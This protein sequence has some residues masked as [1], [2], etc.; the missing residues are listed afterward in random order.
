MFIVGC[1]Y[2]GT[3][4]ALRA[5]DAATPVSGVVRSAA[6]AEKLGEQMIP[7]LRCDLD[8][9]PLPAGSTEGQEVYY[10]APPPSAGVQDTRMRRFIAGLADSGQPRRIVYLSTTG[11][12]GDCHGE[13]VDERRP[14]NPQVDRAHRRWDAEQVLQA[15][16][17]RSGGELVILRVAG[18]YGPGKLPLARLR[19]G[20]PMVDE[21]DAPWTNRIHADDLVSACLAAMHKGVDGEV[22]NACDGN[23]GNMSDY[24][25]QVAEMAGIAPP[26]LISLA[27]ARE[28]LSP[29]MLSYLGESRRLSNAKLL[30]DTGLQLRYPGL[31]E[32]LCACFEASVDS[33][34]S[35]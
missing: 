4:L 34:E 31:P 33:H 7:V 35:A 22:Y 9:E 29:G 27:Q 2:I 5:L 6:S 10:C 1:G 25:K 12:Y 8:S 32:G 16:R 19:K 28:Q 26:P 13:W 24:F 14:A 23:P 20:E 3:R 21:A 30:R 11:V 15:W 18:I 17:E